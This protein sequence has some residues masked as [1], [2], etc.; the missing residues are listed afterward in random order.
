MLEV[1]NLKTHFKTRDGVVKAVDG[2][3]L[4][5]RRRRRSGS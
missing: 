3:D 5:V 2:V 1:N 4:S